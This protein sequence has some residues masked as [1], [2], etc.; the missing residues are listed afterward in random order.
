MLTT[1][2]FNLQRGNIITHNKKKKTQLVVFFMNNK[3]GKTLFVELS[4]LMKKQ[5]INT[6]KHHH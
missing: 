2:N 6:N 3:L 1:A 5:T 4:N